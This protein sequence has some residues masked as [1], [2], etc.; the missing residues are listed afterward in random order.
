MNHSLENGFDSLFQMAVFRYVGDDVH[1]LLPPPLLLVTEFRE[2]GD[3][4]DCRFVEVALSLKLVFGMMQAFQSLSIHRSLALCDD[5]VHICL[6]FS[7][8]DAQLGDQVA[9]VEA[10]EEFS[11]HAE[12]SVADALRLRPL[13]SK[14]E[15][16]SSSSTLP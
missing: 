9:A 13:S 12:E 2:I 6:R 7:Q 14:E 8:I 10:V 1:C 15:A 11:P 5:K 16:A 3:F 4:A